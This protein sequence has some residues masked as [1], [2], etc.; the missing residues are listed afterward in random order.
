[1]SEQ[2]E[3]FQPIILYQWSGNIQEEGASGNAFSGS[4]GKADRKKEKQT[5]IDPATAI[6]DA[7][8]NLGYRQN[9]CMRYVLARRRSYFK[10]ST[11]SDETQYRK[12]DNNKT[13]PP[14]NAVHIDSSGWL[15]VG[16]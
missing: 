6:A 16:I 15:K 9:T 2:G 1:M 14:D 10:A 4:I 8:H 7:G 11:Q 5:T 13:D 3:P 12:K